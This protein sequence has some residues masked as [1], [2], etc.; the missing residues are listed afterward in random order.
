M[1]RVV[2]IEEHRI[3]KQWHTALNKS[4]VASYELVVGELQDLVEVLNE[5]SQFDGSLDVN[6]GKWD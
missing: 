3:G 1:C 4:S 6:N 5:S 2:I